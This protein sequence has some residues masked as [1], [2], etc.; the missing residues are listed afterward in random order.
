M[1]TLGGLQEIQVVNESGLY[2]MIMRSN[3]PNAKAFQKVVYDEILP[4][5]RKNG[6]YALENKYKFILDNNRPLSQLL[7]STEFDREAKEIEHSY[8]WSKNSN[9]PVIYVAY[10]GSVDTYGLLKVGFSD[11]KFDE[12]LSKHLSSESQ[13][14]QFRL[15]NTF[16]VS[17]KP[18][19]EALHNLLQVNRYPFKAQKEVY[20]T[21]SNIK[22]FIST[23]G[24][25]ID[26]ND[27][28][29]KYNKLLETHNRI[30]ERQLERYNELEKKYMELKFSLTN[31]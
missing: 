11:S 29:L 20:K 13:Y 22:Q 14:E 8:D 30:M 4:S 15:L 16:E 12:R 7:K 24:K 23:V 19:E 9:C 21:T 25:L 1:D 2:Y 18:M 31:V 17:G 27:I 26:D 5:I 28:K 6:S 3:K 10:I